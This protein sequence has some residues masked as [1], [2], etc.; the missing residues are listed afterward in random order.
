MSGRV[1][2]KVV[3]ITGGARGQ[4]ASHGELLAREGAKVMLADVL[5]GEGD[6]VAK[7]LSEQGLEVAFHHLD[8]TDDRQ[9][10]DA[11]KATEDRFGPVTVLVNNAGIGGKAS[12]AN[13]SNEEWDRI[14]AVNQT[15]TFYGM[16]AVIP[17]MKEAGVGS[18]VN[19][20][21]Q[22]GHTG[23]FEG[24]LVAY[25][26]SKTAVLGLTRNAALTLGPYGVRANSISPGM[27]DTAMLGDPERNKPFVARVPLRRVA[28][29]L[30]VSHAVVFLASDESS[31]VTG[32]DIMIDG[33]LQ[34]L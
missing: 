1:E 34:T 14:V 7:S 31:Y 33:G 10:A 8:V 29:S 26:A 9:W 30:E 16:R 2:G 12:I 24:E 27:I 5:D 11:V 13:C 17:G 4:G 15:G 28:Q 19:V 32:A 23:G 6:A 18:I 25:V 21:S 20:S 22:I 3:L